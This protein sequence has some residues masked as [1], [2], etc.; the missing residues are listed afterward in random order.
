[1][2]II[3]SKID[4]SSQVFKGN[5]EAMLAQVADLKTTCEKIALGGNE[6]S[7]KKHLER[8]KLLPRQRIEA[9]LDEGSAFLELSQ[10]AAYGY[11]VPDHGRY[12][13]ATTTVVTA[14][15]RHFRPSRVDGIADLETQ[16]LL[17]RLLH[18]LGDF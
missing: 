15:Q 11:G 1:M 18:M 14:F 9:L 2:S 6:R 8:G 12:D 5:R 16:G 7:R 17:S 4:T 13:D 10:L 3:K